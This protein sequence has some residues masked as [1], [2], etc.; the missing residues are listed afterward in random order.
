M[1]H[2][3]YTL[4]PVVHEKDIFHLFCFTQPV[5]NYLLDKL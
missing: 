2:I 1:G 4:A 5:K 3:T